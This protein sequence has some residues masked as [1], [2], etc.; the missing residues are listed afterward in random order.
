LFVIL[1]K[2]TLIWKRLPWRKLA[3]RPRAAN[4]TF[5]RKPADFTGQT[6]E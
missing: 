2:K 4:T 3:K 1:E 6:T 5:Q